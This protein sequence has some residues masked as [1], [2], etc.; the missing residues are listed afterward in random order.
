M[1]TACCPCRLGAHTRATPLSSLSRAHSAD[2]SPGQTAPF[3]ITNIYNHP[4][5]DSVGMVVNHDGSAVAF[6]RQP[7]KL[8]LWERS[9]GAVRE[10]ASGI[11]DSTGGKDISADGSHVVYATPRPNY[12]VHVRNTDVSAVDTIVNTGGSLERA[13]HPS[14]AASGSHVVYTSNMPSTAKHEVFLYKVTDMLRRRITA[15]EDAAPCFDRSY[16][17]S[18]LLAVRGGGGAVVAISACVARSG[19]RGG[20]APNVP[21][22]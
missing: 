7:D 13:D 8:M 18:T 3:T 2:T 19:R 14:I 1:L 11:F 22:P 9:T 5:L 6:G 21:A 15:I 17:A 16:R 10:L 4:T 12:N 20:A